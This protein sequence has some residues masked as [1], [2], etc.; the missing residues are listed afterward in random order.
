[1]IHAASRA[2][3]AELRQSLRAEVSGR[4]P[5]SGGGPIAVLAHLRDAIKGQLREEPEPSPGEP[6]AAL[7]ELATELHQVSRLL[8]VQPR[9]RRALGDPSTA[10]E[11][12]SQFA[13]RI[14]SGKISDRALNLVVDAVSLR[15]S[16]PWDLTDALSIVG[17]ELLLDSAQRTGQLDNVEDELFRF[18]RI[19]RAQDDLRGL[20]DE[21][22]VPA[23]RRIGLLTGV[24]GDK[25]D[26]VTLA[27]LD[28]AVRSGRK[29]TIELAIDDLLERTAQLRGQSVAD[30]STAVA[31][32]D[33]QE[34]R[35]GAALSRLY[36][37][38]ITVRTLVDPSV[39]GGLVVRIGNEIID[40]SVA[41]R[42]AVVRAELAG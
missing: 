13:R 7:V 28:Q 20:L 1:V 35:L 23:E 19:L 6:G 26:P 22:S 8:E 9:L 41:H 29:R 33:A 39:Q 27:L 10:G 34:Q 37:R 16:N 17:D 30:V 15:W 21:Q 18:G 5:G 12:R 2:A 24:V 11:R 4:S 14:L 40:G 32:T 36:D 38:T 42:L 25:V 31:L 3:L